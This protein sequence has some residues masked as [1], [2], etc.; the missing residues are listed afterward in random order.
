M[1]DERV[2]DAERLARSRRT[3]HDGR[4]EG[5][6]DVDPSLV[7]L[8]LIIV[9]HG[10]VDRVLVLVLLLRLFK[11]LVLKVEA[12]VTQL[13]VVVPGDAVTSLVDEHRTEDGRDGV[14]H[15]VGRDA[16]HHAAPFADME[17]HADHNHGES[18]DDWIEHHRPD[19][20]LQALL[21]LGADA[22]HEDE[23]QLEELA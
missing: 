15:P 1:P 21:R 9:Y 8:P 7:H 20:E 23:K 3:Q 6:D 12:V 14:K 4:T 11:R 18:R 16:A 17:H 2:D 22:G 10:D 5:I 13:V 19:V